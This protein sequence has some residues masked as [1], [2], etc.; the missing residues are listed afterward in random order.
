[1]IPWVGHSQAMTTRDDMLKHRK[2]EQRG[3]VRVR[4]MQNTASNS[5]HIINYGSSDRRTMVRAGGR[6]TELSNDWAGAQVIIKT[7]TEITLQII[8]L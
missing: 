1:M 4:S 8:T 5:V 3:G 6:P 2:L 7:A